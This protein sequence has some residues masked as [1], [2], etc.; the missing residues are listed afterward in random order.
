MALVHNAIIRGFNSIYVQARHIVA[1]DREDFI[2]YC[3][4]WHRLV[5]SHLDDEETALFK[6]LEDV[7]EDPSLFQQSRQDHTFFLPGLNQ[8]E[9]Y[10]SSLPKADDISS[11]Q[12]TNIMDSFIEPFQQHLHSEVAAIASLAAHP[13]A[14]VE[15]NPKFK[16]VRNAINAWGKNT[17]SKAGVWD[18]VP[19]FLLNHDKTSENGKWADWPTMPLA[20]KWGGRHLTSSWNGGYWLFASCDYQGLPQELHALRT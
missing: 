5:K 6:K 15:G 16:T 3:L 19:F 9:A 18:V 8:F 20:V 4:V 10:L 2:G 17:V 7:M 11:T 12:L 14:P 1:D 13:R